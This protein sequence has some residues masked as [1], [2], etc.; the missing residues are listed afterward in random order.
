MQKIIV[1]RLKNICTKAQCGLIILV[2]NHENVDNLD[3]K[4][5]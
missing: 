4:A 1:Q 2:Y 5:F 3:K